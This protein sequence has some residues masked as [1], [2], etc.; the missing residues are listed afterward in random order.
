MRRC[1]AILLLA[2]LLTIACVPLGAQAMIPP[3]EGIEG[4]DYTRIKKNE[5]LKKEVE[6]QIGDKVFTGT[7]SNSKTLTDEEIDKII[8]KV[9]NE[10]KVTSGTLLGAEDRIANALEYDASRYVSP[11]VLGELLLA[12]LGVGSAQE[13]SEML[14]GDKSFPST[15]D[16]YIDALRDVALNQLF[17]IAM[18]LAV[19]A[20]F[21]KLLGIA[22]SVAEVGSREYLEFVES[23]KRAEQGIA[24]ALA[25]E[26]FYAKCNAAIKKEEKKN[27]TNSW[28]LS[29]EKTIWTKVTLFGS[30]EVVQFWRLECDLRRET[31]PDDDPAN[32]AGTYLGPMKLDIWHEMS[33][34]DEEFLEK[35]YLSP[36]LPFARG[37]D[38]YTEKDECSQPSTLTKTLT[39]KLFAIT[40][41]PAMAEQGTLDKPF[42]FNGF[43]DRTDFWALHPISAALEDEWYDDGEVHF[44][45]ADVTVD[46]TLKQKYNFVGEVSANNRGIH[47]DVYDWDLSDHGDASDSLHHQQTDNNEGGMDRRTIARDTTVFEDLHFEPHIRIKGVA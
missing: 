9:M 19:G 4:V 44:S 6:F 36:K 32:W 27:G 25:L 34:Y 2:I 29:C 16:F 30:I 10:N 14:F 33:T 17:D 8:R 39:N 1:T 23:N 5:S 37:A 31:A 12:N 18:G 35:F 22:K 20:G 11:R 13:L 3:G 42:S 41:D 46:Y 38:S 43:E 15:A 28:N 26:E 45:E 7:L 21:T 24:A 47:V 40:L